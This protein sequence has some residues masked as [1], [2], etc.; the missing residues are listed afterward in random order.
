MKSDHYA[1]EEN[2]EI[3]DPP[4][5]GNWRNMYLVVLILHVLL[6][7]AFYLFSQTYTH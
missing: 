5:L 1:V 2:L 7:F 6:I 3:D 4:V